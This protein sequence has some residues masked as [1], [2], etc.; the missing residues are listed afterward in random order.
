MNIIKNKED[1][2]NASFKIDK[3]YKHL[4]N[5][6]SIDEMYNVP[7]RKDN[8]TGSGKALECHW[9][10]TAL[11][12]KYGGRVILGYHL[13]FN[14][15]Y[16][17]LHGSELLE[18]ISH[19]CWETPEGKLVD[20]TYGTQKDWCLSRIGQNTECLFAPM[21]SYDA[22]IED[23]NLPYNFC[24]KR[25][26]FKKKQIAIIVGIHDVTIDG[27][28]TATNG[29]VIVP[30]DFQKPFADSLVLKAIQKENEEHP[31]PLHYMNTFKM[32]TYYH[33]REATIKNQ[34]DTS[35]Q[36]KRVA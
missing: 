3:K 28:E 15:E 18:I 29:C 30:E 16:K 8:F 27:H 6:L 5:Y 1:L 4:M 2:I 7:I 26:Y 33:P 24:V 19:S 22:T 25:N 23:A 31:C 34:F 36:I 11:Q 9:N 35:L 21:C 12:R 14:K 20:V 17:R 13:Y 10:V 32:G